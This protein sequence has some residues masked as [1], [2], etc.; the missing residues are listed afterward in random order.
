VKDLEEQM[1]ADL[2]E[3][4]VDSKEEEDNE[5]KENGD[6]AMLNEIKKV[7]RYLTTLQRLASMMNKQL[8]LFMQYALQIVVKKSQLFRSVKPCMPPRRDISDQK[9]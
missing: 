6:H 1:D 4:E 8:N 2:V 7:T 3:D 9:E 5:I